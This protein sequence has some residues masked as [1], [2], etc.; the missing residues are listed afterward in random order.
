MSVITCLH[1]GGSTPCPGGRGAEKRAGRAQGGGWAGRG[2][3]EVGDAVRRREHRLRA[4]PHHQRPAARARLGAASVLGAACGWRPGAR[5]QPR[6]AG[7]GRRRAAAGGAG[8]QALSCSAHLVNMSFMWPSSYCCAVCVA[9]RPPA[10]LGM[11][12]LVSLKSRTPCC[13]PQYATIARAGTL[14][15]R[16]PTPLVGGANARAKRRGG[17]R[18]CGRGAARHR[19]AQGAL[20]G[21]S[22][23]AG[24]T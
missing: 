9:F 8:R 20:R 21:T 11:A 15:Q 19:R 6:R 24:R 2:E 7:G 17:G 18:G 16:T 23:S 4:A 3:D 12:Y 1:G 14:R 13:A 22:Y 10:A 5:P